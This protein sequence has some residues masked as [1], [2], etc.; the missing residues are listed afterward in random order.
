MESDRKAMHG[1]ADILSCPHEK[2][3]YK[4]GNKVVLHGYTCLSLQM[5]CFSVKNVILVIV[6]ALISKILDL[7]PR[8]EKK[9][10]VTR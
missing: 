1:D 10:Q 2:I 9:A 4:I 3:T 8:K 5:I 7:T 6:L